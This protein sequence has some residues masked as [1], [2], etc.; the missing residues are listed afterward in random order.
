M[1]KGDDVVL[2]RSHTSIKRVKLRLKEL[3]EHSHTRLHDNLPYLTLIQA[4]PPVR[5]LWI[6][7]AK[8]TVLVRYSSLAFVYRWPAPIVRARAATTVDHGHCSKRATVQHTVL[9]A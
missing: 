9:A 1:R 3:S 5:V 2:A 7:H 6:G 4:L 8:C